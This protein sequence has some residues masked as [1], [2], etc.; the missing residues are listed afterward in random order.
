MDMT[1][2]RRAR[3]RLWFSDRSVPANEKSYISQLMNGKAPFG[4]KAARRLENDYQMG[5]GYL[6]VPLEDFVALDS[7]RREFLQIRFDL[8]KEGC[9]AD[10]RRLVHVNEEIEKIDFSLA[11]LS[12]SS[13]TKSPSLNG[14]SGPLLISLSDHPDLVSVPRV[15]FKL[16]AGVSGYAVE[17]EEGNGKPVFFRQ[18]W[19]ESNNYRPEKLFAVRVAGASMEPSLWDGDLV[20]IN[21]ADADPHDGEAFAIN[22]EGEMV[23]KRMR[24]DAGE[25]WVT[26]DNADQRRFAPKRCTEG[27]VVIGRVIYKQSERI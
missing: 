11:L 16:S 5:S 24:R 22:Y 6:D 3:L 4:E 26:S 21:T 8:L 17:A 12:P 20:V 1:S 2:N 19:F 18:D 13:N 7:R 15:K 27:V 14:Q 9:N 10:D 25:W 23:I